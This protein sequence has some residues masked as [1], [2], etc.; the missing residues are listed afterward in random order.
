M[1]KAFKEYRSDL[2]P[3]RLKNERGWQPRISTDDAENP[4]FA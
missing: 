3:Y 2:E 1:I 4:F